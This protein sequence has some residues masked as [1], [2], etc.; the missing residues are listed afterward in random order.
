M[1]ANLLLALIPLALAAW[2]PPALAA[3]PTW[4]TQT[5]QPGT[6]P[7]EQRFEGVVEAERQTV[8]AAQV[9]GAVVEIAVKLGDRVKAGQLLMRLD[10]RAAEQGAQAS[11]AQVQAARAGLA[12]AEQSFQRQQQLRAQGFISQGALDQAEAQFKSARAQAQAQLAAAQAARSQT[13]WH[14]VTAPYAGVVAELPVALGDM[15]L[16]GRPLLTLFDPQALR[17]SASL[18]QALA[19]QGLPALE[20]LR[21]ELPAL[22]Q[23]VQ[24]TRVQRLP[25]ADPGSQTVL[26]RLDLPAGSAAQPGQFARLLW[27]G[28]G[29]A[30]ETPRLWVPQTALVQRAELRGVYVLVQGQPQLRW[31]RLGRSRGTF[32]EVLAGLKAGEQLLLEPQRASRLN[33]VTR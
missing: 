3:E 2:V 22:G 20:S 1:N 4:R 26:L 31:V 21:I 28:Q 19:A 7:V 32:V 29:A 9:A 17:V 13:A 23:T 11:E 24:P 30:A 25:L 14:R 16:P 27:P 12:L 10:A 6:V 15:A 18:P 5:L 8:L 33:E